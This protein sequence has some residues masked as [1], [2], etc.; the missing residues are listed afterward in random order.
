MLTPYS[1]ILLATHPSLVKIHIC[2]TARISEKH[3]P[4][5][6]LS[7]QHRRRNLAMPKAEERTSS[8]PIVPLAIRKISLKR[9]YGSSSLVLRFQ[10]DGPAA[11]LSLKTYICRA[12]HDSS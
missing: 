10:A 6:V 11:S 1:V 5:F 3:S 9:A 7:S 4:L 8:L 12:E 2:P